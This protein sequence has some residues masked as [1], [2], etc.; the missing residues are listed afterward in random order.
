MSEVQLDQP[1]L[2]TFY[3]YLYGD[4]EGYVY[5]ATK[6]N[7]TE[8]KQFFFQW[9]EQRAM[10][11]EFTE[12]N[13]SQRDVYTAPA[14]FSDKIATKEYVLGADVVWVEFD[15]DVPT[16]LDGLP[17]PTCRIASG[18]EGHEHWYWKLDTVLT[19]DQLETINR[20]LTYKFGADQSGWDCTQVLRPP[21]TFNHKRKRETTWVSVVDLALDPA[22][23]HGVPMPPP[24]VDA[25][26]PDDIP[27][28]AQ[29]IAS[30]QFLP[31][32]RDL[33]FQGGTKLNSMGQPEKSDALMQLGYY[34]AEMS[35]TQPEILSVL[36]NADDRWGKFKGRDD[37]MRRLMEIVTI[38]VTKH[39]PQAK[40][41]D[42]GPKLVPMGFKTL[43]ATEVNLEWQWEGFLQKNGYFLLTGPSGVGKTQF[44]LDVAGH[45]CL[46]KDFLGEKMKPAKIGFFSLEMGLMDLK[47]F[48]SQMQFSF[49]PEEQD[50]L[51]QSLQ[52]FPL[53]EPL[54]MTDDLV[55]SQLDQI[56]GDLGLD[57]IMVDSL[58]SATDEEVANETFK[59][60]FHW[61]DQFRQRHNAF[62]WYIHHHRKAGGDNKKPNKLAD[63]YGSQYITS[64]ATT[65]ACLWD[66]GIP[67][68]VEFNP[69]KMRLAPKPKPFH[70][71]RD[72]N[73]H[74]SKLVSGSAQLGNSGQPIPAQDGT[75]AVLAGPQTGPQAPYNG[76]WSTGPISM[77]LSES[78]ESINLDL[79]NI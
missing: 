40:I 49:T 53:G 65:V 74:F 71:G 30:Y 3:D 36:L 48:L 44:S 50:V 13:R 32:V 5:A 47:Y 69:L 46:G 43:L 29:V 55:K 73:L 11:V 67:N 23:F 7:N 34:L 31:E 1:D 64:Y 6:E 56:V 72:S 10:L 35:M 18:G 66:P 68:V 19:G 26:V 17:G 27:P 28:V 60:F 79:G 22:L 51:E 38:A 41:G 76:Q 75:A 14:M 45:M 70:M 54:Y 61:N 62:T 52:I 16:E 59:R 8:W 77:T 25:P 15:R 39:P 57:G 37:R 42:P 9:P 24:K 21:G 58:G 63:V 12:L 4:R 78:D 33:F 20:A 2:E